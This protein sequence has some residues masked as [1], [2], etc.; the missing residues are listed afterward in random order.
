ML[1]GRRVEGGHA[2]LKRCGA[3]E[4]RNTGMLARGALEHQWLGIQEDWNTQ[5]VECGNAGARIVWN[6]GTLERWSAGMLGRWSAGAWG[7]WGLNQGLLKNQ[8]LPQLF[9]TVERWN[10]GA[11][12]RWFAGGAN[13]LE[14]W[15]GGTLERWSEGPPGPELFGTV[16]RWNA[17]AL[18]RWGSGIV[19]SWRTGAGRL[20]I[21][22]LRSP[23]PAPQGRPA[24][25]PT[26]P[27]PP[28]PRRSP[29]T[30]HGTDAAAECSGYAALAMLRLCFG[31]AMSNAC[32]CAKGV[33]KGGGAR[34]RPRGK[35]NVC[36]SALTGDPCGYALPWRAAASYAHCA[37]RRGLTGS[38]PPPHVLDAVG[39]A[40]EGAAVAEG[41]VVLVVGRDRERLRV[42]EQ[43]LGEGVE[44]GLARGQSRHR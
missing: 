17:G 32:A 33:R 22:I 16:E 41:G 34:R 25:R 43:E 8:A 6:G 5:N 4:R 40:D 11:L 37:G 12:E 38:S 13:C 9:G 39:E 3:R 26:R 20:E 42:V 18:E 28:G 36:T 10:A 35:E 2:G 27:P 15:N 24:R 29:P 1:E 7:R 23:S 19:G 21:I 44:V 31:Y 14:R 30:P